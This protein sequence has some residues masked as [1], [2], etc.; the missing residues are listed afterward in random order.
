MTIE[1]FKGFCD[2]ASNVTSILVDVSVLG[3]VVAAAVKFRVFNMF[4]RRYKSEVLCSHHSL[5]DG[6]IVF[7][8]EYTVTNTGDRPIQLSGVTLRLCRAGRQAN[9][10]V[11]DDKNVL[12]ERKL[13]PLNTGKPG[14]FT[15]L[16]GERTIYTL[17]C[18]LDSIDPVVFLLCE[19]RWN[20]HREPAP[21]IGMYV[22]TS[23]AQDMHQK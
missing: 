23:V 2:T 5:P 20:D 22:S 15:I 14:L 21:F 16:A 8:G 17:R 9:L 12:A 7:E 19:V 6:G 11:P 4:A 3:A 13:E 1:A 10:F 18:Y